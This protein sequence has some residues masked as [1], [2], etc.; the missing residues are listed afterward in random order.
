MAVAGTE[1]TVTFPVVIEIYDVGEFVRVLMVVPPVME[2]VVKAV[3]Y[4]HLTLPTKA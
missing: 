3:S 4:T 1:L 2:P